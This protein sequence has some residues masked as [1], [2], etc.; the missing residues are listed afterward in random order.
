MKNILGFKIVA[1]RR[2]VRRNGTITPPL[3]VS[4]FH[5]YWLSDPETGM[6]YSDDPETGHLAIP[7]FGEHRHDLLAEAEED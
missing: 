4:R 2:Y 7:G 1:G 5:D 6:A 3:V